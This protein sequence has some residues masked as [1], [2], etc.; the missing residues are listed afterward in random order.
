MSHVQGTAT[1]RPLETV[2]AKAPPP[3]A[4]AP[5]PEATPPRRLASSKPVDEDARRELTRDLQK[6]LRRVG[7]YD[8]EISGYWG[9]ASKRAMSAFTDRVNATLPVEE[10]DYILLTLVQGHAAQAC[11]KSC[12]AGQSMSGD[13]KC[14]ANSVLAAKQGARKTANAAAGQEPRRTA[15]APGSTAP[16]AWSATVIHAEPRPAATP[17][18]GRMAVGAAKPAE[19]AGSPFKA[20]PVGEPDRRRIA[21]EQAYGPA[22]VNAPAPASAPTPGAGSTALDRQARLDQ[23]STLRQGTDTRQNGLLA[24]SGSNGSAVNGNGTSDEEQRRATNG[25]GQRYDTGPVVIYRGPPPPR[26][27]PPPTYSVGRY[28]QG[29]ASPTYHPSA[30]NWKQTIFN[31]ITRMHR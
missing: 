10:P 26:Y 17:L 14:I 5:A 2:A 25:N 12:P 21:P 15:A 3:P 11:G 23:E 24:P 1:T 16:Q 13:G 4:R 28:S 29:P 7:C 9:A 30:R 6:E 27:V 22:I 19:A 31:D 18:P 20:P 8:G